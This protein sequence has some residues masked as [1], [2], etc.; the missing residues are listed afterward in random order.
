MI[1][2]GLR[3]HDSVDLPLEERLKEVKKQGFSCAHVALSKL[4]GQSSDVCALTP[5]YATY[6]K[7]TFADAGLDI[8]VLG[9]YLNLAC[10]DQNLL[11]ETQEKYM[12]NIRFASLLGCSVVGTETGAPNNTYTYD[13]EACHSDEALGIFI[14][15][16]KPV[17]NYAEKMG[18]IMAIEPVYK[19][20][21][22]NPRRARTVLDAIDSPNLQIIFDPVNLLHYENYDQRQEVF[23]EAIDL[24]GKDVAVIHLKDGVLNGEEVKSMGCGVGEIDLTSVLKFAHDKKPYIQATLEDTKP[25][26]AMSC[27]KHIQDIYDSFN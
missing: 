14:K 21:V 1:Q 22:W 10:P 11:K 23:E 19:H 16:L 12:A 26:N 5:G 9:C 4:Q 2:L 20:I 13:K 25:E 15:N 8:A 6:L 3:L 24:F 27:L 17:V 18:V 7:N